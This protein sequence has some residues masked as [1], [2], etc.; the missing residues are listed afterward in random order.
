MSTITFGE[1]LSKFM[2]LVKK[3]GIIPMNVFSVAKRTS[4]MKSYLRCNLIV[5]FEPCVDFL[6]S[7]NI[8]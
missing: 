2:I 6:I 3:A 8:N 4:G 7:F 1:S 5:P